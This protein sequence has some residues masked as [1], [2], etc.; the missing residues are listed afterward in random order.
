L[1]WSTLTCCQWELSFPAVLYDVHSDS[2]PKTALFPATNHQTVT[3]EQNNSL[4]NSSGQICYTTQEKKEKEDF[5][6]YR[7]QYMGVAALQ[8]EEG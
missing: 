8:V 2:P 3:D 4:I 5:Y 7:V 1:P 6:A